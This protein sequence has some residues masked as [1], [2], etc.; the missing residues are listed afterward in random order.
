MYF[1]EKPIFHYRIHGDNFVRQVS[2]MNTQ[3]EMIYSKII[4]QDSDPYIK[5]ICHQFIWSNRVVSAFFERQRTSVWASGITRLTH[6]WD[7]RTIMLMLVSL[8]P[9]RLVDRCI[10]FYRSHA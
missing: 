3:I 9:W 1:S 5:E 6:G 7:M 10:I 8:L 2:T 4:Q